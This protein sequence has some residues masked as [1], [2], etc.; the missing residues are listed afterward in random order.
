MFNSTRN[1]VSTPYGQISYLERGSG[2]TALFV[3]G[4]LLNAHLWDETVAHL[5]S[6][7][8]CVAVD[9][10]G[11]GETVVDTDQDL[12][13]TAQAAMLAAFIDAVGV[14]QVDL[15]AN[16]SGGAIAQILSARCPERVRTLALTNCDTHDNIFPP[17]VVPLFE[18][19]KAGKLLD[20]FE[21]MLTDAARARAF[22]RTSLERS[23]ELSETTIQ[24]F[25]QPL[26]RNER[27]DR[28]VQRWMG[29]LSVDDLLAVE[30]LLERITAPTLV[31]WGTDDVFFD[32]KWAYWLQEQIPGVIDVVEVPGARLF[33][34][35]ERASYLADQIRRLW[36]AV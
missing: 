3:H 13:F 19:I 31:V 20:I 14:G 4:V 22:F 34:P 11:H 28:S 30:P 27:A 26:V 32:V 16:D 9:L 29:A 35:L 17:A 24:A 10:M 1:S 23:E 6:H 33:F 21:P 7:R 18:A 5:A 12:S 15:V 36:S 25:V 8:R 2:P